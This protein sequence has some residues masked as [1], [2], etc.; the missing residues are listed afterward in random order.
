MKITYQLVL[1]SPLQKVARDYLTY[2]A[3]GNRLTLPQYLVREK[4]LRNQKWST[5][6]QKTWILEN[7]NHDGLASCETYEILSRF[8][9][10]ILS[11]LAIAS[12]FT[13]PEFRKKGYASLLIKLLVEK[14]SKLKDQYHSL[15]LFS[16]VGESIYGSI[17]FIPQVSEEW[18]LPASD[19]VM[20]DNEIHWLD[21][22][23][24]EIHS[25]RFLNWPVSEFV[26]WPNLDQIFWHLKRQDLYAAFLK[27]PIPKYLGAIY[28][29][30]SIL[31][32]ADYKQ[33]IL[34]ALLVR[35]EN[36]SENEVALKIGSK[37]SKSLGLSELRSWV[38]HKQESY[39]FQ[40]RF[41][42]DSISMIYPIQPDL[43]SHQWEFIPRAIWV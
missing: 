41:R 16:E 19:Q 4:E 10:S 34:R 13:A 15:V 39:S 43:K 12:V 25:D 5:Y 36:Q 21:R 2:E 14:Y 11:S 8:S 9:G 27:K 22:S 31:W 35:G 32:V 37:Y 17:G 1:A 26:L 23:S 7:Q 20:I 38:V 6:A 40:K 42:F 30:S 24:F 28:R 3:W 18:V 29:N 33:D